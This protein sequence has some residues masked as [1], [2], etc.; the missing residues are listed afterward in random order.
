MSFAFDAR[1]WRRGVSIML[2]THIM[3]S[4]SIFRSTFLLILHLVFLM[5]L[6]ITHMVLVHERM[7]L[8]LE[9][10]MS[11]YTFIMMFVLRVGRFSAR[12]VYSHFEPSHF[13]GPHFPRRGSR[14]TRSNGEVQRIVKTSSDRMVKCWIPN[15]FLTNP[16][17]EP[18]T[19]SHSM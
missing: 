14:P 13:D 11:I 10:L 2:E 18:L 6:T 3:M 7:V 8:C 19:F 5:D 4:S 1:E 17:I 15:L 9:A 16:S 12:D